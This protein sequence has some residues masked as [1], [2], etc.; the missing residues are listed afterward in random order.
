MKNKLLS[1]ILAICLI[2]PCAFVLS[3]CG[4]NPPPENPHT[5]EWVEGDWKNNATEHWHWCKGCD[6][7]KDKGNHDGDVCSVCGYD[8]NHTHEYGST[9][10]KDSDGHWQKCIHCDNTTTKENHS[11]N[12]NSCLICGY[13]KTGN[14]PSLPVV[15][16]VRDLEVITMATEGGGVAT[17]VKLPDGKNMVI[18]SGSDDLYSK[19]GIDQDL[20]L[21]YEVETIDYLVLTN[22]VKQLA[23]GSD[24]I[25]EYYPVTNL[26]IPTVGNNIT[27]STQFNAAVELGNTKNNCTVTTIGEDNCDL[28]YTFKDSQGN[29]HN[30]KVDFMMPVDFAT[31]ESDYD[32]TVV[33]SIEYKDKTIMIG[34]FATNTNIESYC[35]KYG[36]KYDVDVLITNY[37]MGD[38]KDAIRN[39]AVNGLDY[40]SK[41]SLGNGDYMIMCTNNGLTGAGDLNVAVSSLG[42]EVS[43][44][45]SNSTTTAI[46]T[47]SKLGELD[48]N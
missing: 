20:L 21:A 7:K 8:A 22:T 17:L 36:T 19:M 42:V 32:A 25:F 23:G 44:I 39:S 15:T 27:P 34:G 9:Y 41:I 2:M 45:R 38:N 31:A 28:D 10:L 16:S 29:E 6:E 26:Y 40:L 30:Y 5:H 14:Q 48:V 11:Y 1:F 13:E 24:Y 18:N 46:L 4:N 35:S 37:L 47:I 33:I 43:A 12:G 3:A